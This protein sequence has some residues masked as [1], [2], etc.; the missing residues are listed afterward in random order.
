MKRYS[1]LIGKQIEVDYRSCDMYL[2]ATGTLADDSGKS[3]FLEERFC[4]H[5]KTK[6]LRHEIPYQCLVRLREDS[7]ASL[8]RQRGEDS[9]PL[10][11]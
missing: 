2:T 7:P 8:P 10:K 1:S 3:I 6:M 9:L 11:P 4:Q 5:G